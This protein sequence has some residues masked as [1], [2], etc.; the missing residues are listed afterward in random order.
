MS[1]TARAEVHRWIGRTGE[2][3]PEGLRGISLYY[4]SGGAAPA[5]PVA[6]AP[7]VASTASDPG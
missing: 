2:Q 5:D 6:A 1:V 4:A 7:S 3:R